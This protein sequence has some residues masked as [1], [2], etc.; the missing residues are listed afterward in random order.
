MLPTCRPC[1]PPSEER[2]TVHACVV[3]PYSGF[4]SREKTFANCL[5]VDFRGENFREFAGTQCTTPTSAVSN[6][7]KIDF[8]RESFRKSPLKR[9]IRESFLPRKKPAIRYNMCK[10]TITTLLLYCQGYTYCGAGERNR[11]YALL[12]MAD[13][14]ETALFRAPTFSLLASRGGISSCENATLYRRTMQIQLSNKEAHFFKYVD[15]KITALCLLPRFVCMWHVVDILYMIYTATEPC[16]LCIY[17]I[18]MS[19]Y[20]WSMLQH[21]QAKSYTCLFCIAK[22]H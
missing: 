11:G 20:Y 7:L 19:L 17:C 8:R 3:V 5:K 9:E 18:L 4:L 10:T 16:T 1:G 14:P 15:I 22:L 6:C 12:M 21:G 2:Y 13:K